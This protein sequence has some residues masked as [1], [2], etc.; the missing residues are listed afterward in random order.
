[1]CLTACVEFAQINVSSCHSNLPFARMVV[2]REVSWCRASM[3]I[4]SNERAN[5]RLSP[6]YFNT[7]VPY[8]YEMQLFQLNDLTG[9]WRIAADKNKNKI[10]PPPPPKK[11]LPR[12]VRHNHPLLPCRN[13]SVGGDLDT[14]VS[15]CSSSRRWTSITKC[16]MWRYDREL[17]KFDLLFMGQVPNGTRLSR[18]SVYWTCPQHIPWDLTRMDFV[19][20]VLQ[21][22]CWVL[23]L[24]LTVA[25]DIISM[26]PTKQSMLAMVSKTPLVWLPLAYAATGH[27]PEPFSRPSSLA[28]TAEVRAE[29]KMND[30]YLSLRFVRDNSLNH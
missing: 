14:P 28:R 16:V 10:N 7:F 27:Y 11:K 9:F 23:G 5:N 24:E 30:H 1:M 2:T 26:K 20:T 17:L 8:V 22:T 13:L 19:L 15:T 21:V 12:A 3:Q 25:E 18:G 6:S 4:S 29:A